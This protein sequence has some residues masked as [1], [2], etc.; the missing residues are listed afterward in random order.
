MYDKKDRTPCCP[1]RHLYAAHHGRWLTAWLEE[2]VRQLMVAAPR[3]LAALCRT[4]TLAAPGLASGQF[5]SSVLYGLYIGGYQD[6][7]HCV[8]DLAL[9]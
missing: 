3:T 2:T 6:V 9:R 8:Y 4:L 5:P 1:V 7:K